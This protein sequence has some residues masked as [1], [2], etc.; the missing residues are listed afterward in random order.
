MIKLS[1]GLL[2]TA[3][4]ETDPPPSSTL[5]T[6][7]SMLTTGMGVALAWFDAGL[8]PPLFTACT[9][10]VCTTPFVRPVRVKPSSLAPPGALSA[11][12]VQEAGKSP[13]VL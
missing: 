12:G 2:T 9:S 11:M 4:T 1:L 5:K 6:V 10:K 8:E 13:V 3:Q 7:R